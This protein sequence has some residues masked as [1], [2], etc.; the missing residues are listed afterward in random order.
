MK[1]PSSFLRGL[2]LVLVLSFAASAFA[3]SDRDWAQWVEH[4]YES[5]QPEL[6]V[7][8][9]FALSQSGYFD[10]KGQP[11]TAI[12]FLSSVF[13]QNPDKVAGWMR[14]FRDLPVAH[15]RLTVAALWY[16]GLPEGQRA[17]RA[18]ARNTGD[19]ALRAE[20]NQ[21]VAQGVQPVSATPVLSE[22]S[23]NLQWGAFLASGEQQHIVNTLAALGSGEPGLSSAAWNSLAQNAASHQRIYEI[24][25]AQLNNQPTAVRDQ[26]RTALA[27]AG[28]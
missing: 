16:S 12:G 4:Y 13:A 23:L 27:N 1:S 17:L 6:V 9:V 8:A 7:P 15:Q 11:A 25:Q 18:S 10:A 19:P 26:L 5:P 2:S 14:S 3:K 21:L 20:L 24:C 22:S 28:R